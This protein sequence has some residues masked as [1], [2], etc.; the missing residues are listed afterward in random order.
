MPIVRAKDHDVL[1][2]YSG[3]RMRITTQW[4]DVSD[5]ALLKILSDSKDQIE[6]KKISEEKPDAPAAVAT[7][8][9][10][11][12]ARKGGAENEGEPGRPAAKE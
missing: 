11:K 10:P 7:S 9:K 4:A 1:V 6:V 5:D 12:R 8:K 3:R 2:R